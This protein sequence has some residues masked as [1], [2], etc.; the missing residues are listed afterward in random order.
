VIRQK[1]EAGDSQAS[2]NDPRTEDGQLLF[3]ERLPEWVIEREESRLQSFGFAGQ[4]QQRPIPKDGGSWAVA[5]IEIIDVVPDGLQSCRG[6]D[7]AASKGKKS[8]WSV[9]AL[10][11]RDRDGAYIIAH[12]D[13]QRTEQPRT[14]IRQRA[15]LDGF[16]VVISVPQD[17][18]QAGKDQV[19][20]MTRDF[21]GYTFKYSL[22]SG[23]KS[24]RWEPFQSQVNGGNVKMVRG[25]WNEVLL[26]EMRT[27]GQVY[28]DQLD[29]LARAFTEVAIYAD[30][31]FDEMRK[32][33]EE[34]EKNAKT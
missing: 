1:F 4:H 33:R 17:P 18:G 28:K 22:E 19:L 8:P 21:A 6:W 34:R 15:G 25:S 32:K 3:P 2:P 5:K 9:G 11:G 29:A 26:D 12:I 7:L 20:S 23:E 24:V 10:L 16:G 31:W 13:R 30:P 27:N 14:A